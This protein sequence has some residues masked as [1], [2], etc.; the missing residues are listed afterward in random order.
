MRKSSLL[1]LIFLVTLSGCI[2]TYRDFPNATLE[3]LPKDH[4]P[5]PLYYHVAPLITRESTEAPES[6]E[7]VSRLNASVLTVSGLYAAIPQVDP[8]GQPGYH[9]VARTLRASGMFS[10]LIERS[11]TPETGV[12]CYVNFE[13]R[14]RSAWINT[15][16]GVHRA[17]V[18]VTM[19][20]FLPIVTMTVS[21]IIRGKAAQRSFTHSTVMV[22]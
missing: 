1:L 11:L 2:V 9:E 15:Y 10:D 21:R 13:V 22:D 20:L 3:S 17:A 4:E 18:I 16:E 8:M 12:Y 14:D 19:G 7:S 5:K 6:G